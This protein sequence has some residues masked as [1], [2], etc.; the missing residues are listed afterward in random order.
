V[1]EHPA[2]QGI[3]VAPSSVLRSRDIRPRSGPVMVCVPEPSAG[4]ND[5]RRGID[6][7]IQLRAKRGQISPLRSAARTSGR[8]D[9]KRAMAQ[10]P[11]PYPD[12]THFRCVLGFC[13]AFPPGRG[14]NGGRV[15]EVGRVRKPPTATG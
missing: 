2:R 3:R 15:G 12:R 6:L 9:E 14:Y 1:P 10:D 5:F 8:N 11:P 4:F 13:L 7:P